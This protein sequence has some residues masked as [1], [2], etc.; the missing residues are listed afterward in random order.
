MTQQ[1]PPLAP[2][3]PNFKN[4]GQKLPFRLLL[5]N[6]TCAT[7]V[8]QRIIGHAYAELPLRLLPSYHSRRESNFA[9]VDHPEDATTS[10]EDIGF[11]GGISAYGCIN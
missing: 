3:V 2:K 9:H 1:R 6:W 4:K 5:L 11:S 7:I 8:D 10:M